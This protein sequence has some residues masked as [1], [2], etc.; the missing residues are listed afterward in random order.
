KLITL[1]PTDYNV[2]NMLG[3][4][5]SK[6]GDDGQAYTEYIMAA[7]AYAKQ[8]LQ[9]K[10]QIIYKKIARLDTEKL[11]EKDKPRQILIKKHILAEKYIEDGEIDK[12][13]ETYKEIMK[14]SPAN[15]D[16]YQKLGELY[17]EKGDKESAMDCYKKIVD[18]YFK[19]RLYKKALPIYQ[20]ILEMH[21]E[22][23]SAHERIADIYEREGDETGA[24]REYLLLAEHYWKNNDVEKTAHFAEKA[25]IHK[26]IDAHYY[27]GAAFYAKKEL[28]EAKKEMEMLMKF[29]ANHM[30]ALTMLGAIQRDLGQL[31]E[32]LA[33]LEKA[34]KIEPDN[35]GCLQEMAA[36]FVKKGNIKEAKAKYLA[37]VN[38]LNA[39][40][41]YKK[42][43][44]II[45]T[46]LQADSSSVDLLAK[47]AETYSRLNEKRE[48]ADAY[49][50]IAEIYAKENM[51][52]KAADN[53]K[54]AAAMDPGHP[55]IVERAKSMGRE[56]PP[57]SKGVEGKTL[58]P[59]GRPA[60]RDSAV[61][62]ME[63]IN[64]IAV[65]TPVK[66]EE[67]KQPEPPAFKI[68]HTSSSFGPSM[69]AGTKTPEKPSEQRKPEAQPAAG[70]KIQH[71]S[72]AF[73]TKPSTPQVPKKE[74]AELPPV[75]PDIDIFG[76]AAK[77]H[78]EKPV[79]PVRET[80]PRPVF[81][82]QVPVDDD[83]PSLVAMADSYAKSGALDEAI[84]MY[85]K[86]LAMEPSNQEIKK[87]L[88]RVYTNYAGLPAPETD[89]RKPEEE[90]KNKAEEDKK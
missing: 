82:P 9:D 41:E 81:A 20:K 38:A 72:M 4:A 5:Y 70:L 86:A 51:P 69:K 26:S 52:D 65:V 29:K 50:E 10:A 22:D 89:T 30:G 34:S 21:P 57:A 61:S 76:V 37:A 8:G 73:G 55:K 14:I 75:L 17:T 71:T 68:Q 79:E 12:A 78:V 59:Q 53:Y 15:F 42:A 1:D 67:Q 24:K 66:K 2:H 56:T 49:I 19:N 6:K 48:A 16:V 33:T 23:I 45:K 44:E 83:V 60:P 13:I 84:E 31:D 87:K 18:I 74:E 35:A 43:V 3:D 63:I 46:A 88:N 80:H 40:Q 64:P 77:K 58:Q 47:L 11:P 85:Q 62:E 7:E 36:L 27:K 90:Q 25:V 54:L 39:R 32:A 28:G